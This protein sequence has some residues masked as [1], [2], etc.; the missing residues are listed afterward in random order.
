VSK[1]GLSQNASANCRDGVY[2]HDQKNGTINETQFVG[3]MSYL[4]WQTKKHERE[5]MQIAEEEKAPKVYKEKGSTSLS[6]KTAETALNSILRVV[7]ETV[8]NSSVP[9]SETASEN[10]AVPNVVAS[11]NDE[12]K[13]AEA[14]EKVETL[15]ISTS[16]GAESEEMKPI[17]TSTVQA[18]AV[19][20][21]EED[22][23]HL[24]QADVICKEDCVVYYWKLKDLYQLIS[25]NPLLGLV[26]KRSFSEAAEVFD[27]DA[28]FFF[29][30]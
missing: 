25:D 1:R 18:A 22:E 26:I 12:S 10:G 13:S 17:S 8:N 21:I 9:S 3:E 4:R 2:K 27:D 24:G 20:V 11:M 6:W 16:F 14:A 19:Q 5:S 15:I 28:T 23:G 30:A 7:P 29:G